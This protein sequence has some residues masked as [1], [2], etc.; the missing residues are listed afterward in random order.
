MCFFAIREIV[1]KPVNIDSFGPS[2]NF[3]LHYI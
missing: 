3:Q 1:V 2:I